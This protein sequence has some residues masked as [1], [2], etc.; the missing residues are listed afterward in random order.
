MKWICTTE[1]QPWAERTAYVQNADNQL[2]LEEAEGHPLLGFG[3]CFNELGMRALLDLKEEERGRVLDLLFDDGHCAFNFCR[4]S[5]GAN[6]FAESWYSYNE[7]DGDYEMQNFS[8]ERDERLIIPFVREAQKRRNDLRLFASPWSP[9]I[10]M[11]FPKAHN[12]GTLVQTPENLKA[13]ALYFKKYLLAY[14]DKGIPIQQLHVQNEPMSS[15]K[16]PSCVWTGEEFVRFISEY[17]IDAVDGLADIWIGTINGPETDQRALR[18]RYS[19][20]VGRVMQDARCRQYVKGA[21]YQ[22]AG[23]FAMQQTHDDY[24]ELR[25]I[26]SESECGD[27]ENTWQFAL[28]T[29]EMMRHYFRNGASAYVYWN[30]ALKE[31]G[32][33]TW[34]WHQNSLVVVKDG[35]AQVTPEFYLMQHFSH[36]VRRGARVLRTSGPWSSNTVAFENPDGTKVAVLMNPYETEKTVS[37]EEKNLLL[38]PRSFHTVCL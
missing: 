33:S 19:Q 24:P 8:I 26:Q 1:M 3:G 28:Y 37:V 17:L 34:G 35:R 15:Q 7:T 18:T 5:V 23:K 32:E 36:F 9:P 2:T 6:D 25:L 21:S 14:K 38:P 4:L 10:W 22:W 30:M 27:G 11:K 31:G 29:F 20:Y 16:F 12:Y 13:Y